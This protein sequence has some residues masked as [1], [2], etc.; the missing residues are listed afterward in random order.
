[1]SAARAK[2]RVVPE[3]S[4]PDDAG[5]TARETRILGF[6]IAAVVTLFAA[7]LAF[8]IAGP[9]RIGDFHAES[10]FFGFYADG[11]KRIR[12][13]MFEPSRYT[14]V[15]PVYE[16]LLTGVS[17]LTPNLFIGA[18][19]ISALSA[20][21]VLL[22][23]M[24]LLATRG[25][26]RLALWGGIFLATNPHLFRYAY[27]ATNDVL[28][29][30][31]QAAA[32]CALLT[33]RGPRGVAGAGVLVALACLTRYSAI[34][35]L[36][37][38]WIA[39]LAG[40]RDPQRRVRQALLF[41][42]GFAMLVLPW[43]AVSASHVEGVHFNLHHN[44]AYEAYARAK[45]IAW[46]DY[47]QH[48]QSNF[49]NLWDVVTYDP[50]ALAAH[51]M[52]NVADH[53]MRD[54]RELLGLPMALLAVL[55]VVM[56]FA[57][58]RMAWLRILMPIAVLQFLLLVPVFYSARYALALVPFH[59][60]FAAA[61]VA[62]PRWALQWGV[63]RR[64][65]LKTVLAVALATMTAVASIRIEQQALADLPTEVLECATTLERLRSPGDKIIARKPHIAFFANVQG[66]PFPFSSNLAE[67]ATYAR[68]NSI[69][70]LYFS[71]YE[72]QLRPEFWHLLDTTGSV[73]GLTVR[74]ATP[75][76]PAV[77]YEIGAHF[78]EAPAW[79][80]NDTLFSV[81]QA[82]ARQRVD[83]NHHEALYTLGLFEALQRRHAAALVYLGRLAELEKREPRAW[84]AIGDV[85][86]EMGDADR[87]EAAYRRV[88]TIE[89]DNMA[90]RVGLG[91]VSLLRGRE[92]EAAAQWRPLIV[93]VHDDRTLARMVALFASQGDTNAAALA[94]TTLR[95][96][97]PR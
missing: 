33:T 62:S 97:P 12:S 28:A 40:A 31:L 74:H 18:E 21:A 42:A 59:A 20:V 63:T 1:M 13:G 72:A 90:A 93:S 15:G 53:L 75:L 69:R 46:D 83:P 66:V 22:L 68:E 3:P 4:V 67:L 51:V 78:G 92:R 64:V 58:R 73:P 56:V 10:D 41:T 14:V 57:D 54:A 35:L 45:G 39:L 26:L 29:V 88:Q 34:Y 49:T 5:M 70:W 38:G 89:P 60:A 52:S 8:V 95:A 87:A 7:A 19:L 25:D 36:P 2:S 9:H 71:W 43:V 44:I 6:A 82:R 80:M 16:F 17:W 30:A 84:L 79:F 55:G 11:V 91:W 96:L 94:A 50:P 32:L 81:H 47:Q 77:L 27:S 86:I 23:W 85:A 65:P 24:R 37:A 61:F 76:R 48:L